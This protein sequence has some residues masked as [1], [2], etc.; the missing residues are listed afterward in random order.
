MTT[1][2]QRWLALAAALVISLQLVAPTWAGVAWIRLDGHPVLE[3]RAV[4]GAQTPAEVAQR[5]SKRLLELAQDS[6]VQPQAFMVKDVPP[7][8][9]VIGLWLRELSTAC[10]VTFKKNRHGFTGVAAPTLHRITPKMRK[11]YFKLSPVNLLF[12][13]F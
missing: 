3:L 11:N 13:E 1:R 4:T 10:R 2:M 5:G 9:M 12:M 6:S 8:A 7:Y